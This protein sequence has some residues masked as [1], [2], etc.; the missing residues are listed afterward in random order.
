MSAV[1]WNDNKVLL[2]NLWPGWK[3][4]ETLAD[5]L[6]ARW[7]QLRQDKLRE[8]IQ[9]HRFERDSSPDI[10][11]IHKAYA[12]ITQGERDASVAEVEVA[13]TQAERIE[14]PS[15]EEL[16]AWDR[17]ADE[18]IAS[19]TPDE[20]ARCK[21]R[22]QWLDLDN[23]RMLGDCIAYIRKHPTRPARPLAR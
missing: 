20:I 23:R 11:A 21:E 5:L 4:D 17:Y 12:R 6:N 16:A 18:I 22:F 7:S 8:C 1:T 14:G 3:P 10:S 15:P 2:K 19:A 9:N 13:R